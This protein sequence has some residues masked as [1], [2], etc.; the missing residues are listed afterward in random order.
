MSY[1][2]LDWTASAAKLRF[3]AMESGMH[4][5]RSIIAFAVEIDA[6]VRLSTNPADQPCHGDDLIVS[7]SGNSNAR[8]R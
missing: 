1:E 3:N 2:V 8:N 4:V 5:P 6:R 7:S